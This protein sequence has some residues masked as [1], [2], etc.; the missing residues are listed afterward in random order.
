MVKEM[1]KCLF[2]AYGGD[3]LYDDA[4]ITVA[5]PGDGADVSDAAV[6]LSELHGVITRVE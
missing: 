6:F 5:G 1:R 2:T 3:V 4:E